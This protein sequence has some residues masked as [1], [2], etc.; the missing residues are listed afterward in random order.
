[1][2]GMT[3][4]N[5]PP[6]S[7]FSLPSPSSASSASAPPAVPV[8]P[9][10]TLPNEL[11]EDLRINMASRPETSADDLI[12]FSKDWSGK[13]RAAV[14]ANPSVPLD[15]AVELARD[16]PEAF[17]KNPAL[18]LWLIERPNL[19]DFFTHPHAV[20][21][22]LE[23]S[24]DPILINSFIKSEHAVLRQ[25]LTYNLRLSAESIERLTLDADELVRAQVASRPDLSEAQ[26]DRLAMDRFG[27]EV[28]IA[29]SQRQ[30]LSAKQMNLLVRD[31]NAKVRASMAQRADLDAESLNQLAGDLEPS[32]RLVA[33]ENP[34]LPESTRQFYRRLG[35]SADL[36]TSLPPASRETFRETSRET[37]RDATRPNARS[38]AHDDVIINPETTSE[39]NL[40]LRV[41]SDPQ[42]TPW[43]RILATRWIHAAHLPRR[44]LYDLARDPVA[45]IRSGVANNVS[46]PADLLQTLANDVNEQVRASVAANPSTPTTLLLDLCRDPSPIVL[47]TLLDN[48]RVPLSGFT[49]LLQHID[50]E[51][52]RRAHERQKR[53]EDFAPS[54]SS[55]GER[56]WLSKVLQGFRKNPPR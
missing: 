29:V 10:S 51:I 52:R 18:A 33:A 44:I 6:P 17:C 45:A 38:H 19:L 41:L 7:A 8:A 42:A 36:Q 53:T 48:L 3:S 16:Y 37:F 50:P 54:A 56:H 24:D 14:A 34:K 26:V 49:P 2:A 40:F 21:A 32:V 28:R 11:P 13:V 5:S 47:R 55:H 23:H 27:D 25:R 35:S 4:S 22:L 1:M 9:S 39:Q 30:R 31:Q 46:A 20:L 12:A 43:S 15:V